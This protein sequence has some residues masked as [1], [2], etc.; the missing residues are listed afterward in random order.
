MVTGAVQMGRGIYH[1]PGAMSAAAAGKEWDSERKEWVIYNLKEEAETI[2]PMTPEQYL[3]EVIY[4]GKKGAATDPSS[5]EEDAATAGAAG[6]GG[7]GAAAPNPNRRVTEDEYYRVLGVSPHASTSE[8]KKAYYVKA[9]QNHPDR[10]PDDPDAHQK[11]QKIGEAYQVLSDEQ[12]R[13]NYD[14][15]GKD[16][17]EGAPKMDSA[18][19]F[20]MIFGSEKFEPLV[21]ELQLAADM[22]ADVDNEILLHPRLKN[23]RQ[24]KREIQC[25]MNLAAKL[26]PYIDSGGDALLFRQSVEEE[27][28]ELSSSAFGSTLLH[29]IG[30]AYVEYARAELD[31]L[32]GLAVSLRQT[33]RG[34]ATRY[35]IASNGLKAASLAHQVQQVQRAAEKKKQDGPGAA[36]SSGSSGGSSS[37]TV[38]GG[39]EE[40]ASGAAA[41]GPAGLNPDDLDEATRQKIAEMSGHMMAVMWHVTEL[42]LRATLAG[43]CKKVS[44]DRSVDEATRIKRKKGLIVLGEV[45]MTFGSSGGDAGLKELQSKFVAGQ[46]PGSAGDEGSERAGSGFRGADVPPQ[47][48]PQPAMGTAREVPPPSG[49]AREAAWSFAQARPAPAAAAQDF[50]GSGSGRF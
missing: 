31:S 40:S 4:G 41:D 2:L 43:V 1:T 39:G 13:A 28:R 22:Q 26:Q 8:I 6:G 35:A 9:R 7:K 32:D 45:Y 18:A 23:F 30:L 33:G 42:D 50:V 14:N 21:G 29:T 49:G 11:F 12:L 17:V 44:R 34:I 47:P 36:S 27:A 24:R 3:E 16:G 10:H 5:S 38:G 48:Q 19:M 15:H 25:A 46:P 37:S 20:A